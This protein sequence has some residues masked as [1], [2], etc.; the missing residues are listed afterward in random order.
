MER[1]LSF[2]PPDGEFC[3]LNYRISDDF[4]I[5]FRIFPFVEE[6]EKNRVDVVVKVRADLPEGNYGTN[7]EVRFPVPKTTNGY[8]LCL[9]S[10]TC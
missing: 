7:V 3:V 8:I 9:S 2:F 6:M 5:P 10:K 1:S 4:N